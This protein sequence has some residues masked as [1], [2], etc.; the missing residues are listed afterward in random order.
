MVGDLMPSWGS[1]MFR[2]P[3]RSWS[4][5]P[6]KMIF[7]L[8]EKTI[9]VWFVPQCSRV[10][11]DSFTSILLWSHQ[12]SMSSGTTLSKSYLQT[13]IPFAQLFIAMSAHR[14][15]LEIDST[16][17]SFFQI[18]NY[19]SVFVLLSQNKVFDNDTDNVC[20]PVANSLM[21]VMTIISSYRPYLTIWLSWPPL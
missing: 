12:H 17:K 7:K 9:T 1:V 6:L 15:A 8:Q 18:S 21:S 5:I 13:N 16:I 3:S 20:P 11:S 2:R 4:L 19:N 14:A 10:V